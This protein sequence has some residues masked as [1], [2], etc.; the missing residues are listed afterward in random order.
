MCLFVKMCSLNIHRITFNNTGHCVWVS[1]KLIIVCLN[2]IQWDRSSN[3]GLLI[4]RQA[5]N[6]I[7]P[8]IDMKIRRISLLQISKSPNNTYL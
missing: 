5:L 2:L 6:L 1:L 3:L 7:I 8:H 4:A